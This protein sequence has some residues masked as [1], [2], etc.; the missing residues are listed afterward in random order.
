LKA[1]NLGSA[2]DLY[3]DIPY[4]EAF[5]GSHPKYDF[6]ESVLQWQ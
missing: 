2:T 5:T 4:T 3:G 1:I 6:Q